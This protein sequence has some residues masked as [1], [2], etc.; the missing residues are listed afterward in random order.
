MQFPNLLSF[1]GNTPMEMIRQSESTE[2]GL[3]CL[4]MISGFF[5]NHRSLHHLRAEFGID[6]S[7]VNFDHLLEMA[8]ELNLQA[9]PGRIDVSEGESYEHAVIETLGDLTVP[10]VLHW[11]ANHFVVLK[12]LKQTRT[13]SAQQS[14]F[15]QR[16]WQATVY[17]PARGI[18]IYEMP[19]FL[20]HFSTGFV[21]T[22]ETVPNFARVDNREHL[23]FSS[24]WSKI[25]GFK[26][27]VALILS[28]S[29]VLQLCTMVM[30]YYLQTVLD[31]VFVTNDKDLL[32]VLAIGFGGLAVFERFTAFIRGVG[33]NI[34]NN[35]FNAQLS[36][37]LYRHL[38]K[39]P[40]NFFENRSVGEVLSRFSSLEQI[41]NVMVNGL[42]LAVLDGMMSVMVLAIMLFY[43]TKLTMIIIAMLSVYLL[44]QWFVMSKNREFTEKLIEK[45]SDIHS[46]Q[47]ESLR[48]MQT[49]KLF[50]AQVIR[51]DKWSKS[52]QALTKIGVSQ[53]NFKE[54]IAQIGLLIK[55]LMSVL[56]VYLGATMV[57]D[58]QFSVGMFLA[59]L[60]Y[61]TMLADSLGNL[62][63]KY[64]EFKLLDVHF[65]RVADVVFTAP[66]DAGPLPCENDARVSGAISLRNVSFSYG[67]GSA[68][69]VVISNLSLDIASGESVAITGPS[70]SGKTTLM[71]IMLGLLTPSDGEVL[72]DGVPLTAFGLK[73]FRNQIATVMQEDQLLSGS[74]LENITFFSTDIDREWAIECAKK[75]CV[76]DDIESMPMKWNTLVGDMGSTLSGGQKQRVLLARALYRKP[77]IIFLDEATSNLDSEREQNINKAMSEMSI[78]RVIIA[79]RKETI[80]SANRIIRVGL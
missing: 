64:A 73:K 61:R 68:K 72:V 19:E 63:V 66:E 18:M 47:I 39:L 76:F 27:S 45:D 9:S 43:S 69:K 14:G 78:T 79:H 54:A 17:D 41:R 55:S 34:F 60:A 33:A 40:Q 38:L 20:R 65:N 70:G 75:A 50:N 62:I 56:I 21:M 35:I 53:G 11:D 49:L 28:L 32:M 16:R 57:M 22:F 36:T 71:K 67:S 37:G 30:P 52:M 51:E 4:A 26:R 10:V 58:G 74:I 2:C 13:L 25:R 42:V 12:S 48:S 31:N 6:N 46:Q 1:T 7:G 44:L 8:S 23:T 24:L 59:F 80:E 3:A 5:G 15:F 29:L 77:K